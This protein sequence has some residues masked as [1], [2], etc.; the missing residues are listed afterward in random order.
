MY[1]L[2][3]SVCLGVLVRAQLARLG[4]LLHLVVSEV[5]SEVARL[6]RKHLIPSHWP[7]LGIDTTILQFSNY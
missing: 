1:L 7:F 4:P 3:C 5:R 6:C 2:V